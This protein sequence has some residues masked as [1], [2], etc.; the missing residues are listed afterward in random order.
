MT[1]VKFIFG[2]SLFGIGVFGFDSEAIEK[3][4]PLPGGISLGLI[5]GGRPEVIKKQALD[6]AD[7]IQETFH[8]P[9]QIYVSKDYS[10]LV[11]AMK[12]KRVDFAF[13]SSIG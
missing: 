3:V 11:D 13:F 10:G 4:E 6:L 8:L 2:L 5:P 7:K 9:V 1:F 12:E